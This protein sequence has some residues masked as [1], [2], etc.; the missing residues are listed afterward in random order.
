M[1]N[2]LGSLGNGFYEGIKNGILTA[3]AGLFGCSTT[4]IQLF[5]TSPPDEA[6]KVLRQGLKDQGFRVMSNTNEPPFSESIILYPPQNDIEI[7]R[8]LNDQVLEK[9]GL[10]AEHSY[11]IP[12]NHIGT[13]EYTIG[14]IGLYIFADGAQKTPKS[15]SYRVS[16]EK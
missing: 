16:Q 10:H 7:E 12:S 6:Q 13:H 9:N 14:N 5:A 11:A 4:T 8:A 3:L 15:I 1:L 2:W